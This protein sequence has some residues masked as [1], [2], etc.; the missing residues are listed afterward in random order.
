[1]ADSRVQRNL[2][3]IRTGYDPKAIAELAEETKKIS[4]MSTTAV[5]SP[6]Y[7]LKTGKAA[8]QTPSLPSGYKVGW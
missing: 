2:E 4:K 7:D 8:N 1:M 3:L 6:M 5:T